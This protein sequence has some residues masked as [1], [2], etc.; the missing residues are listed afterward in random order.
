MVVNSLLTQYNKL[1]EVEKEAFKSAANL[2]SRNHH[3]DLSPEWEAEIDRRLAQ[4]HNGEASLVEDFTT[5]A[6]LVKEY[7][8]EIHSSQSSRA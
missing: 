8:L 1:S 7:G 2:Q 3:S 6:A 4:Y 5:E